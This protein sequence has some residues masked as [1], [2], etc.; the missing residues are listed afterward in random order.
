MTRSG[1]KA[2]AASSANA[3]VGHALGLMAMRREQVAEQLDV[4]RIVFD[5]EDLGQ[6][7]PSLPD[8]RLGDDAH[9]SK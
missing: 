4:E 2:R 1:W 3:A 8:C 5:N 9:T 7:F 6:R